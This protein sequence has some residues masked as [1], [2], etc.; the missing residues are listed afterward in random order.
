MDLEF[1]KS[2]DESF[3]EWQMMEL[4]HKN[5]I[6]EQKNKEIYQKM[7]GILYLLTF[8]Y[9]YKKTYGLDISCSHDGIK[10]NTNQ[11]RQD[12]FNELVIRHNTLFNY[13]FIMVLIGLSIMKHK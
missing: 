9:L 13:Y 12:K 1:Q 8:V 5:H 2:L 11:I 7:Y 4:D 3:K 6:I 10:I